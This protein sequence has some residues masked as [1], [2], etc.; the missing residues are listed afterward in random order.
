M[1]K[2]LN[3]AIA[4]L[5]FL[6][7]AAS[8]LAADVK[9]VVNDSGKLRPVH[10]GET[11]GVLNGGTGATTASGART[12]LSVYS[13][14]EVDSA[15]AS[16]TVS[17]GDKGDLV[18][19]SSGAVWTVDANAIGNTKIRQGA[20]LSV[21]GNSTNSTANVADITAGS[22]KQ[23]LR[24]SG[25]AIGFGAVDLSSSAAVTGNLPVANL[26]SGSSASSSTFWRGDGTWATVTAGTGGGLWTQVLSATPTAVSTGLSNALG[27]GAAS[28]NTVVGQ[29]ISG[30][31][32]GFGYYTTS[33]PGT[34]YSITALIAT[35]TGIPS[36]GWT[37]GTKLQFIYAS[38]TGPGNVIVQ[39]NSNI[40][41]FAATD[42]TKT[43][44][45]GNFKYIWLKIADDG[46][47]VTFS[48]SNDGANFSTAYTVA[49]ASGY[50]GGTGYTHI[51][52]GSPG[53]SGGQ[54]NTI[55]SWTQG[56]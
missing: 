18:V 50:L 49:K 17:D 29:Y 11:V 28:S 22:D 35:N 25:T 21:I 39:H 43:S 45:T 38:A 48:Y 31:S 1:K 14:S 53:G 47:N 52:V 26:N 44:G 55:M 9:P 4:A 51:F 15:V 5:L 24:R 41:T 42:V 3:G 30:T 23:V 40:T 2:L 33:V 37:D 20:A 34:P 46:T 16:G 13:K 12:N 56:S 10:T 7:C 8:V 6:S 36:L 54:D 19:S 32:G 27:T